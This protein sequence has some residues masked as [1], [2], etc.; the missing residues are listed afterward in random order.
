MFRKHITGRRGGGVLLYI[1]QTI[2]A[3][4]VQLQE[5]SDYNEAIMYGAN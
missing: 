1:K 3:Y 5:E 2:P 4:E